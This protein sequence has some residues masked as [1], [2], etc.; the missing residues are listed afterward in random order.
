MGVSYKTKSHL[1]FLSGNQCAMPSCNQP[2]LIKD[3]DSQQHTLLGEVAHIAG[4]H[5]GKHGSR[6][7]ARYDETMTSEERDS[8]SNLICLCSTCH[9]MIDAHPYGELNYPVELLRS[10]KKEHEEKVATAIEEGVTSVTFHE[11]EEATKWLNVV[12]TSTSDQNFNRI[13]IKD[14][15]KKNQLSV[16]SENLIKSFIIATPQVRSFIQSLSQEDPEF[17][18]RLKSG[19]LEHYH[20]LIKS[21]TSPGEDPFTSMCLFA[22]RGVEI[23]DIKGQYAALAVLI[24]LFELCEVFER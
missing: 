13:P 6:P 22:R 4:K 24:Y 15:I 23:E 10:I 19:F 18:D 3:A 11:L 16:P 5:G 14:K 17:P 1:A 9:R 2:L 7:S 20:K 8:V 12:E 21:G